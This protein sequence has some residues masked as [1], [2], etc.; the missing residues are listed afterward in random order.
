[1]SVVIHSQTEIIRKVKGVKVGELVIGFVRFIGV[2]N[3]QIINKIHET[4]DP[5]LETLNAWIENP[6][7]RRAS[8]FHEELIF[9]I[10]ELGSPPLPLIAKA[11]IALIATIAVALGILVIL[12]YLRVIEVE[13]VIEEVGRDIE[14][15]IAE[16]EKAI[17]EGLIDPAYAEEL[18]KALEEAKRKAEDVGRTDWWNFIKPV[19][20]LFPML[21]IGGIL[22]MVLAYLPRPPPPEK[23]VKT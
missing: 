15:I 19:V 18:N 13:K 17:E 14:E 10:Y 20:E 1:M 21:L 12:L 3:E 2:T 6:R 4:I 8:P 16:K 7:F 11:L 22:I 5:E 23:E 9:D